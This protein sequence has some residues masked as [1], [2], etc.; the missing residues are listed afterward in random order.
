M[1]LFLKIF[2]SKSLVSVV[3]ILIMWMNHRGLF[4]MVRKVSGP[5]L[6][7]KGFLLFTVTLVPFPTAVLMGHLEGP[8]ATVAAAFCCETYLLINIAYN[9]GHFVPSGSAS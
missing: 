2:F 3:A 7:T 8:S 5:F 9:F 4:R 1:D 6:V